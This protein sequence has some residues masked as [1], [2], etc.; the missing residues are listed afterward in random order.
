ML[1]AFPQRTNAPQCCAYT[2]IT[3]LG[4]QP[5]FPMTVGPHLTSEHQNLQKS[6]LRHIELT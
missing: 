3:S 2:Y 6:A 1:I 5:Q 4:V